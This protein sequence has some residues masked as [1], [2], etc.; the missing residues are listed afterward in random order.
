VW[1]EVCDKAVTDV[2][3]NGRSGVCLVEHAINQNRLLIFETLLT[4]R[5]IF[6]M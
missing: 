1:E 4:W 6:H 3:L 2:F 5:T